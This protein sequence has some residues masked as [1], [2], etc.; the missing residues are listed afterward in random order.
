VFEA[1]GS[2]RGIDPDLQAPRALQYSLGL[3]HQVGRD[4]SVGI[5]GVY[6]NTKNLV[7]WEWTGGA[8][9]EV[10]FVDPFTGNSY[11]LWS[12]TEQPLL[13]K[14]NQ[15]GP[16]PTGITDPYWQKYQALIL[17]FNKRYSNGW[18]MQ[19]S[20][21]Y[22]K[23]WGL[24]PRML[25]NSQFNPFYGGSDGND[26]NNYIN[27]NQRLQGDRPHMF[28]IAGTS[29]LPGGIGF[30]G[31][32][33]IQSGRPYNRQIRVGGLGQG[34][35]RVIMDPAGSNSAAF[36]ELRYP[37]EKRVD[38]SLNKVF[39]ISGAR[40]KIDAQVFNLLNEGTYTLNQ[41]LVLQPGDQFVRTDFFW[42]RRLMLRFGFEF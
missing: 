15:P 13:F 32:I 6:K 34:T 16:N 28:R 17:T 37:T 23:S 18:S 29:E 12:Q 38:L 42:P 39:D 2:D 26:P 36:G 1:L 27:A 7:G 22:S 20:Y 41:S 31:V 24:I 35:S 10:P 19:A 8:W 33:N 9:Q 3:E 5:Q 4:Y 11:T 25:T 21:T 14:G 30:S 40:L